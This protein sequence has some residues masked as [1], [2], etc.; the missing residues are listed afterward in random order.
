MCRSAVRLA[1]LSASLLSLSSVWVSVFVLSSVLSSELVWELVWDRT[2]CC[3]RLSVFP[4]HPCS[5]SCCRPRSSCCTAPSPTRRAPL[6]SCC[7][8]GRTRPRLAR[9]RPNCQPCHGGQVTTY[10][11]G[12]SLTLCCTRASPHRPGPR[13]RRCAPSPQTGRERRRA[14]RWRRGS[15]SVRQSGRPPVSLAVAVRAS[16]F[17]PSSGEPVNYHTNVMPATYPVHVVQHVGVDARLAPGPPAVRLPETDDP[18]HHLHHSSVH[19]AGLHS[20]LTPVEVCGG[21]AAAAVAVAAV[22]HQGGAAGRGV[23]CL[24]A[25][26]ADLAA[27]HSPPSPAVSPFPNLDDCG[28]DLCRVGGGPGPGVHRQPEPAHLDCAVSRKQRWML[29]WLSGPAGLG[30]RPGRGAGR[31][32]QSSCRTTNT[33]LVPTLEY[34]AKIITW[35]LIFIAHYTVLQLS[36]TKKQRTFEISDA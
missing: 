17:V 16:T 6:D 7:R 25:H 8:S 33:S 10:E 30:S 34:A 1:E 24:G 21:E 11:L 23:H 32:A 31:R 4:P 15:R 2:E 28:L 14:C 35:L 5:C 9:A 26:G 29:P 20:H 22:R 3:T 36:T 27:P 13:C 12:F 18:H 19:P